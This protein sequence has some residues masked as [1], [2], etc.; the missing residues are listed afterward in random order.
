MRQQSLLWRISNPNIEFDSYLLGTMHVRDDRAFS[1]VSQ[2]EGILDHVNAVYLEA[3]LSVMEEAFVQETFMLKDGLKLSN[4]FRDHIYNK[5]RAIILKSFGVDIMLYDTMHPMVLNN[6]IVSSIM[7][8]DNSLALDH[9]IWKLA[10]DRDL[11]KGGV[12][13]AQEQMSVVKSLKVSDQVNT[14]R[15]IAR[16]PH[17]FRRKLN[18]LIVNYQTEDIHNLYMNSKKGMGDAKK[19]L[20]KERNFR[21]AARINGISLS[22]PCLFAI[23]AGHLSGNNGVLS[24]LKRKGNVLTPIFTS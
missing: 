13:T 20:L 10:T 11:R 9:H 4:F 2:V 16:S 5:Y 15:D 18:K 21:M 19:L 1:R 6:A 22:R 17:A 14:I 12:E 23:G 8:P 24:L 3:D 7:N